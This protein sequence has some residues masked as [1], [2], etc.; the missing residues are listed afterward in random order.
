MRIAVK[1]T[2]KEKNV[3]QTPLAPRRLQRR[4]LD[5]DMASR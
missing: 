4:F 5:G 3:Q 2:Q 1:N